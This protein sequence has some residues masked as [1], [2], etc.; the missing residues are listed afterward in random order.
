[1]HEDESTAKLL[2]QG[3]ALATSRLAAKIM[4]VQHLLE[5]H[6]WAR[7]SGLS[8]KERQVQQHYQR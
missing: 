7:I 6:A 5:V 1:M 3:A 4:T 8:S 2:H